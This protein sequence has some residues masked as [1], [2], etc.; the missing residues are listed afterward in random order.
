MLDLQAPV[1]PGVEIFI[2]ASLDLASTLLSIR[3]E[4]AGTP[5]SGK[6]V[7]NL[8]FPLTSFPLATLGENRGSLPFQARGPQVPP[9]RAKQDQVRSRERR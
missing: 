8:L 9:I 4:K 3:A 7:L 6:K 2:A 1:Q 5:K